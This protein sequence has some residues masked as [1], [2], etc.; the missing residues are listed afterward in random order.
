M[1]LCRYET[2]EFSHSLPDDEPVDRCRCADAFAHVSDPPS[3]VQE[4]GGPRPDAQR[5]E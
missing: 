5:E 3:G 1:Y 2:S 4:D